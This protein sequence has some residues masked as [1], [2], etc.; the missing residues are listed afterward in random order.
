[1]ELL[2][3]P[4]EHETVESIVDNL[5]LIQLTFNISNKRQTWFNGRFSFLLGHREEVI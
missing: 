4:A 1:M 3:H 5:R 2:Q